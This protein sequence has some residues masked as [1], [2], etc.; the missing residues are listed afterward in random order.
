VGRASCLKFGLS[1]I[2]PTVKTNPV[3]GL[4]ER[5]KAEPIFDA[6]FSPP[7][8]GG[9]N[10]QNQPRPCCDQDYGQ[11]FCLL[12]WCNLGGPRR[13]DQF[14]SQC[15]THRSQIQ[16]YGMATAHFRPN[17]GH[18]LRLR[19]LTLKDIRA[20]RTWS[21]QEAADRFAEEFAGRIFTAQS[22]Q[23]STPLP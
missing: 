6:G 17:T 7:R 18:S 19:F 11:P 16:C 13:G 15:S 23:G 1:A 10:R 14:C 8:R 21:L 4:Q 9:L 2:G 12:F 3:C 20:P 5:R 22:G